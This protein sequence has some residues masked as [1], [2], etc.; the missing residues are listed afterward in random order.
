M[1]QIVDQLR[2][3]CAC[4]EDI[5][6]ED[7]AELIQ[8]VSMATCWQRV[9]CETFLEGARREVIELPSCADCPIIF[10]PYYHPFDAASFKFHLVKVEGISET[11][12]EITEFSYSDIGR[13]FRIDTGLPS[14]KCRC[15]PC[16][17]CPVQYYLTVDYD[18]GY[19]ELPECLL[20]V[21]CNLLEI[22][23][24]KRN[25]NCDNVCG[26]DNQEEQ[27]TYAKG[28]VVSVQL[29]TELGK[30]LVESYKNQLGLISLCRGRKYLWGVVV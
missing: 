26:C 25:C 15:D 27:V 24:A 17:T 5:T 20:P 23:K 14:C 19:D 6:E 22:I 11:T 9:Q 18:A 7:V 28:D 4:V 30:I 8:V 1:S 2:A 10:E 13:V 21:F 12:T 29:E 3:Y 16:N